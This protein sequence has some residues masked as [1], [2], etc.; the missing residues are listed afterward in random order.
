MRRLVNAYLK[1]LIDGQLI[2]PLKRV[3]E[4]VESQLA[5]L[6]GLRASVDAVRESIE[7][8]NEALDAQTKALRDLLIQIRA[9]EREVERGKTT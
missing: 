5:T 3:D 7:A 8:H 2:E 4:V 1:G 6:A 9:L